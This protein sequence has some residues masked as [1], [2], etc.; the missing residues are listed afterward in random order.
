MSIKEMKN[1]IYQIREDCIKSITSFVK[2][3]HGEV[4][5]VEVDG[6]PSIITH[7]DYDY[8]MS[9]DSL[10]IRDKDKKLRVCFSG[11]NDSSDD[12]IECLDCDTLI[13]LADYLYSNKGEL[14]EANYIGVV[15]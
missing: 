2:A 4:N 1:T 6:S 3:F 7:T 5:C 13:E 12:N 10:Y 15:E 14:M 8:T 9:I 11:E